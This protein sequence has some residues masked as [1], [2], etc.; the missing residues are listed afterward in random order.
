MTMRIQR[1]ANDPNLESIIL[2]VGQVLS[3]RRVKE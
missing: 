1:M 2:P 3:I